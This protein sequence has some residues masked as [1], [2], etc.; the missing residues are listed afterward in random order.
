MLGKTP[1]EVAQLTRQKF[2]SQSQRIEISD[3]GFYTK[4]G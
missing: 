2:I 1:A 4:W 3:K